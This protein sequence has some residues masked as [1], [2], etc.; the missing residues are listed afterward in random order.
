MLLVPEDGG[1]SNFSEPEAA[2]HAPSA[3]AGQP[4]QTRGPRVGADHELPVG[5]E[6]AQAAP[7]PAHA[8][9]GEGWSEPAEQLPEAQQLL[10][11]NRRCARGPRLLISRA[12]TRGTCGFTA[13]MKSLAARCATAP[14]RL[15]H[16]R[17]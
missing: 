8:R 14:Y 6:R 13:R 3:E 7:R 4:E 11:R 1:S 2:G 5:S 15:G 17:A 12:T 10:R 16:T 9:G